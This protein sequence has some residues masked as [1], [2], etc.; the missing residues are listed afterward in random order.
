VFGSK[1]WNFVVVLLGVL[2]L[3]GGLREGRGR[4]WRL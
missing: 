2:M 1:I 3:D 4:R